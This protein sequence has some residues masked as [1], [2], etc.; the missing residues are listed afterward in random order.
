MGMG[1]QAVLLWGLCVMGWLPFLPTALGSLSGSDGPSRPILR[2]DT[3]ARRLRKRVCEPTR[4]GEPIPENTRTCLRQCQLNAENEVVPDFFDW[5]AYCYATAE[6]EQWD[7]ECQKFYCCLFG[8]SV[9]GGGRSVC[10]DAVAGTRT[11]LLNIVQMK[12][13]QKGDRCDAEKCRGFCVRSEFGTCR[14]LQYTRACK[15]A[16][17][18]LYKCDVK[19]NDARRGWEPRWSGGLACL[20]ALRLALGSLLP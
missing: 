11:D 13:I 19:C 9:F 12:N 10:Y 7:P 8:C 3:I 4:M 20:L 5:E 16:K 17:L 18:G 2:N 1:S 14:E 15:A 6:D